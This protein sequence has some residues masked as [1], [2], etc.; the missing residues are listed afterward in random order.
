M[1]TAILPVLLLALTMGDLGHAD[2]GASGTAAPPAVV[3]QGINHV[4][5]TVTKLDASVAFFTDVLGWEVAGGEPDYPSV[6]V[7]DGKLFVTLWRATNP[8]E[9]VPFDRKNNV[10]LHHLAMTV[11]SFDA[12]DDLHRRFVA[13]GNVTI[14]FSPEPMGAGPTRHMMIREPSGNRLEFVHTPPRP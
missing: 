8:D 4:G 12:L 6:F 5:L 10:G 7:T 2:Q 14:E 9:A 1:R 13:A 11:G 3:T